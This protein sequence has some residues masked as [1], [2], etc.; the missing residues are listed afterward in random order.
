MLDLDE[1]PSENRPQIH[2]G[3]SPKKAREG[4][5]CYH[6]ETE[7]ASQGQSTSQKRKSE[8]PLR[9]SHVITPF[10]LMLKGTPNEEMFDEEEKLMAQAGL[11]LRVA[12]A[13]NSRNGQ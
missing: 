5:E 10:T 2:I 9:A 8:H 1:V 3:I 12:P 13:P 6:F 7:P 4:D 11:S